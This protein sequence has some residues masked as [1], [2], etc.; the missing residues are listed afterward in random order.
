MTANRINQL[1]FHENYDAYLITSPENL[2]YFSGFTGGEG[3]LFLDGNT[4]LLFTDSRYTA[5]AKNEA[6]GFTVLD[7]AKHPL[8]KHLS[9]MGSIAIGFED[10]FFTV[11]AYM[12][13]KKNVS[14]ASFI[15]ASKEFRRI[16]SIKDAQEISNIQQAASIADEAFSYILTRIE[17]GRTEKEIALELEFFMRRHGAEGL[18]FETIAASGVRSALPHGV[19]TEKVLEKGD[20]FTLDFGCKYKG[21]ASDM[22]RT[23]VIGSASKR[24]KEIYKTV[25]SAQTAALSALSPNALCKEVDAIA[26]NIIKDAGY[27]AYFGH[28]LGHSVGLKVHEQP[29]LSPRSEQVLLPNVTMTVE[30]G[31]YI[32]NFGGVRIEDLVVITE[33]GYENLT[34]SPKELIEI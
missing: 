18:S 8:S 24:Q 2:F 27:G 5:Q 9:E 33:D 29:A 4:R 17:C 25:L 13:L 34:A 19:A 30:P 1:T 3:A 21:Y 28:G 22:T 7:T 14:A 16:R 6:V 31:I 23:V 15:P 10:E 26:R 32:E 11:F 12:N 20:F